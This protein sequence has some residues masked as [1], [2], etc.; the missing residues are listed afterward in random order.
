MVL[1]RRKEIKI[2]NELICTTNT[3]QLIWKMV[4]QMTGKIIGSL[5]SHTTA[6][7]KCDRVI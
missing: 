7:F 1:T 4:W 5:H 6:Q 3:S 2:L